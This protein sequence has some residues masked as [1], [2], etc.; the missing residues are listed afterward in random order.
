M[1]AKNTDAANLLQDWCKNSDFYDDFHETLMGI[2]G[3]HDKLACH[4]PPCTS[5][6]I[7][8]SDSLL[9]KKIHL[10]CL[11]HHSGNGQS[12]ENRAEK[13]HKSNTQSLYKTMA[14]F[15]ITV[16]R[17]CPSNTHILSLV[18]ITRDQD[19][20]FLYLLLTLGLLLG[21]PGTEEVIHTQTHTP[22]TLTS[23]ETIT[24]EGTLLVSKECTNECCYPETGQQ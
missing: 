20:V 3:W 19:F 17:I 6:E 12:A 16:A 9:A 10:P 8:L 21:F 13:S 11:K 23:Q 5:N 4:C 2:K 15:D 14:M 18:R 7:L 24:A 1:L 22:H